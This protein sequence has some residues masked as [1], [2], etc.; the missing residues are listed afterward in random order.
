MPNEKWKRI[1]ISSVIVFIAVAI[2][3]STNK[4]ASQLHG[5]QNF[6]IPI[7][8]WTRLGQDWSLFAPT[9]R[10]FARRYRVDI[11][12]ADGKKETWRRPW[13]PN[14]GFFDRHLAYNYQ[15]WD[16]AAKSLETR[17][18]LWNDLARHIQRLYWNDANPPKTIEFYREQ[19][20]WLP[21][22]ETGWAFHPNEEE[23]LR[24]RDKRLFTYNVGLGKME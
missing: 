14:W 21:P 2:Q 10:T 7:L 17:S 16:L 20:D 11:E 8:Q 23:N 22:N 4:P 6:F 9:P 1:A 24:W 15:K 18:P 13:P 12:F 3:F 19:A 5:L